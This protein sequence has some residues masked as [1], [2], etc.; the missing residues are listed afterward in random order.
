M[1][2]SNHTE[3][4]AG[5]RTDVG[6]LS[7]G[8]LLAALGPKQVWG[9]LAAAFA[10]L[11]GSFGL[12]YK[13]SSAVSESAI[14]VCKADNSKLSGQ[15]TAFRA[16]QTKEKFLALYLR[17]MLSKEVHDKN[18]S[19]ESVRALD[20]AKEQL[21]FYIETLLKRG[22]DAADE[23]ELKGLFLGKSAGKQATVKFGYD[24]SVWPVPTAFGFAAMGR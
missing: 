8:R 7:I 4:P 15:I 24:G 18:A 14:A 13:T 12:G 2:E 20:E 5:E 23:I 22:E 9:L 1:S 6:A 11:S 3:T 21:R 19:E 16:I 10:L 17:Y